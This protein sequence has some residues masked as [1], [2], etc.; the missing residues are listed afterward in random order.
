MYVSTRNHFLRTPRGRAALLYGG[1]VGRL[2]RAVVSA[3]DVLRGPAADATINGICLWDGHSPYAYWDDCLTEQEVDL[4]CG[5]YHVTT[6]M[7]ISG[8][9]TS[10]KSWWPRPPVL[11]KSVLNVGWWTPMCEIWF[12]QR[13][14]KSETGEGGIVIQQPWKHGLKLERKCQIYVE[15]T[16]R[17]AAGILEVLRP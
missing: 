8:R 11:A 12:Q 15:A 16:E 17:C 1:I 13:L 7:F 3:E 14:R 2:A 10:T 6:G 9:Q 4:I 5:V